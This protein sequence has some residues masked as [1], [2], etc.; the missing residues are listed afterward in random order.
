MNSEYY[1]NQ[2]IPY[3]AGVKVMSISKGNILNTH[4]L[5]PTLQEQK[6]IVTILSAADQE[7]S[8]LQQSLEQEKQKKKAL[9]QLLLTGIVR[10]NL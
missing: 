10:V 6:I 1:H 3:I 4:L 7:I 2:L 9:M 5:V 8:L